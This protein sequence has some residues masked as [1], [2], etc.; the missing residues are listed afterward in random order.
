MQRLHASITAADL[1]G[2]VVNNVI[3]QDIYA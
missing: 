1:A 3:S 2:A